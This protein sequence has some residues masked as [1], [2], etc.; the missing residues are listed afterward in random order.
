[1]VFGI[2]ESWGAAIDGVIGSVIDN[3]YNEDE[4]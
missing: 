2:N 1:M 3:V 4:K